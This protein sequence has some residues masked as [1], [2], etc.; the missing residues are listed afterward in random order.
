MGLD[1]LHTVRREASRLFRNKKR[2]YLKD[3]INELATNNKSNNVRDQ[4]R[5]INELKRGLTT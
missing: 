1:N 2:E 3:L 4:Y 5:G